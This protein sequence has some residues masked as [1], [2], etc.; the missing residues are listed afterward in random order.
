MNFLETI[1][2]IIAFIIAVVCHEFAHGYAALSQGDPTAKNAGRLTL[3]PLAHV[4]P[5]GLIAMLIFRI[6]WAKG[7]P[8][9]PYNFRDRRK[10]TLI[11]SSAGILTNLFIAIIASII[12]RLITSLNPSYNSFIHY[13]VYFLFILMWVNVMLGVFNLMP[14]PPLDG[15]KILAS[16]LP[17]PVE[18][19]IYQ[20]ER[21]LY[22]I[23]I[24]LIFTG[25]LSR[26]IMPIINFIVGILL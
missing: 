13:L 11:V 4:D 25:T 1:L 16:I 10:S 20:N 21:Y 26:I 8:V 23:L 9:N 24:I 2:Y 18:R 12:L 7:V 14:F 22:F 3:N 17:L 15:S 6:G 5:I 19:F